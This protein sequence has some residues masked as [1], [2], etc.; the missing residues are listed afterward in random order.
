MIA[1]NNVSIT[2]SV[3]DSEGEPNVSPD[4]TQVVY[5]N[6]TGGGSQIEIRPIGGGAP[7]VVPTGLPGNE[8][9]EFSP[10]GSRIAFQG[11]NGVRTD[12]YTV[13]VGGGPLTNVTNGA[14]VGNGSPTW[15]PDGSRIAFARDVGGG[16]DLLTA[17]SD[18]SGAEVTVDT[19]IDSA[20]SDISPAGTRIA[21]SQNG[22]RITEEPIAGG[23]QTQI[24]PGADAGPR[25]SPDGSLMMYM[26]LV[27]AQREVFIR[28]SDGSGPEVNLTN[29]GAQD[30]LSDW[31][32]DMRSFVFGSNRNT[33]FNFD[34]H[35]ENS[36]LFFDL[37]TPITDPSS[38]TVTKNGAALTLNTDYTIDDADTIRFTTT[39]IPD[40]GDTIEVSHNVTAPVAITTERPGITIHDGAN[41]DEVINLS[42]GASRVE[43]LFGLNNPDLSTR[44]NASDAISQIDAALTTI[45]GNLAE[46]GS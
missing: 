42:I 40:V 39:G 13:A 25:Y 44:E 38:V 34:I 45:A 24:T 12:I 3:F 37:T 16:V 41:K 23:A 19:F 36:R 21:F 20:T 35:S 4:G 28:N 17:N 29:N 43:D 7:V 2:S 46:L 27:G 14:G 9:P 18:G 33:G 11:N 8:D 15:S 5:R 31:T 22:S 26:K 1:A 10:D 30:R 32:P 6:A